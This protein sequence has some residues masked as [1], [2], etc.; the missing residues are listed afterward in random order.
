MREWEIAIYY[1]NASGSFDRHQMVVEQE[2]YPEQMVQ[3]L[4][5]G[6]LVF[7]EPPS[8]VYPNGTHV[9]TPRRAIFCIETSD[10]TPPEQDDADKEA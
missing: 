2:T 5:D 10:M 8:A 6:G 9:H 3:E 1:R 7:R 4:S